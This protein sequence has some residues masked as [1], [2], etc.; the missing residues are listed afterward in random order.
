[1]LDDDCEIQ[2]FN[3]HEDNRNVAM[4][5]GTLITYDTLDNVLI[6]LLF[7]YLVMIWLKINF[8]H[9]MF[10]F[11]GDDRYTKFHQDTIFV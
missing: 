5:C 8:F 3:N 4:K 10:L 6:L 9:K 2:L 11:I 1:M 7:V